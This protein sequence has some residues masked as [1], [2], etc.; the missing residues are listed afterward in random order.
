M[1]V[2]QTLPKEAEII[3]ILTVREVMGHRA[4]VT[5]DEY[6]NMSGLIHISEIATGWI[7]NIERYIRPKQKAVLKV[8]KIIKSRG[9]VDTSL[10]Q[11]SAEERKLKI[12]E[13]EK[14]DKAVAFLDLSNPNS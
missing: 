2:V 3:I 1:D 10:K 12:I 9:E 14:N 5:L 6:N 7:R 11:V 13:A 4:Y 8:I